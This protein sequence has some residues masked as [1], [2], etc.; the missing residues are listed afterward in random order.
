VLWTDFE[1]FGITV[2][3]F[4]VQKARKGLYDFAV[5]KNQG[6]RFT[7][8]QSIDLHK[9]SREWL[10]EQLAQPFDGKTVVVTHH[11]PSSRSV[12]PQFVKD[13]LTPAFASNLDELMGRDRVAL[14]I[15]GYTH[16][17]F[18]YDILGTR[19]I[20]NPRGYAPHALT[21]GFRPNLEI[22]IPD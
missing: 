7:P 21:A 22:E 17:P 1:L 20:C 19:V 14:W 18:D 6:K 10:S 16:D 5:I 11:L 4:A 3:Y 8:D 15:D 9:A 12:A 2:K 13:L